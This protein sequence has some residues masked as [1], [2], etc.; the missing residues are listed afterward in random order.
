MFQV[1]L[2]ATGGNKG[3]GLIKAKEKCE[4]AHAF[5]AQLFLNERNHIHE[6]KLGDALVGH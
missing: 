5:F 1:Y 2:N 3:G 4:S 6:D